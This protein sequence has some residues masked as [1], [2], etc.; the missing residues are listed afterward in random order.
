MN[1]PDNINCWWLQ[2]PDYVHSYAWALA[3]LLDF[4]MDCE[5]Y[6]D[7]ARQGLEISEQ[8]TST[9]F[10]MIPFCSKLQ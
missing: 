10:K 4:M 5:D 9:D 6:G 7:K 8:L 3:P 1:Q 2:P